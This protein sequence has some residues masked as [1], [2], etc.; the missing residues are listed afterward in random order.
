[1]EAGTHTNPYYAPGGWA[2]ATCKQWIPYGQIHFHDWTTTVTIPS[3]FPV[4]SASSPPCDH[5]VDAV[6]LNIYNR[7]V[8]CHKCG[9][10]MPKRFWLSGIIQ[11]VVHWLG[12]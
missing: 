8:Q 12:G 7:A 1:M 9:A 11:S 5:P 3:V 10:T 4:A 6:M 2:C